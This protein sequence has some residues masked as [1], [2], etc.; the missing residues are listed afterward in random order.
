MKTW[1]LVGALMSSTLVAGVASATIINGS[2]ET[3]DTTG[4]SVGGDVNVITSTTSAGGN[5]YTA[6]DGKYFAQINSNSSE[7]CGS[8]GGTCSY[9]LASVD[10]TAGNSLSFDWAFLTDD[11]APYYDMAFFVGDDIAILASVSSV[12]D[13][14][15]TG[16]QTFSWTADSTGTYDFYWI[17]SNWLDDVG[18]S[19]LLVD[20]FHLIPEPASIALLSLGVLGMGAVARRKRKDLQ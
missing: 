19:E 2:F 9:L 11:Y 3:G 7:Y 6:T 12:G 15:E 10:V 18:N 4:F 8:F 17:S 14:G 13:F 16:W 20:N 5:V 1:L